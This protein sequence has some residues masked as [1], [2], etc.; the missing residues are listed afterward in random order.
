MQLKE[1]EAML[2]ILAMEC[3]TSALVKSR[4]SKRMAGEERKSTC[5]L[6]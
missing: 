3:S 6:F 1:E 5:K 4:T 2:V